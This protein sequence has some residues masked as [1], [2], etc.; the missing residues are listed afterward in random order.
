MRLKTILNACCDFKGFVVGESN[1]S[2]D[3]KSI[4]INIRARKGSKAICS[5]CGKPAP[6]YDKL[7]ERETEFIPFW[8]FLICFVYPMRRV[9]CPTCGIKVE[10]VPWIAGKHQISPHYA[11]YLAG[12]AK[13]MSWKSVAERFRTSWQTVWRCVEMVVSYGLSNRTIKG[14]AALGVDEVQYQKGHT[15]MTLVYQ[16]DKDCRRLL[17][18]GKKRTMKT[19][20]SFFTDMWHID[21]KFRKGIKVICSDMWKAYLRVI[22]EKTPK[23]I[24]VL[25]KFH[26]MK[27]LNN[28]INDVRKDEVKR[29]KKEGRDPILKNAK[30]CFLKRKFN[31]TRSQKGKLK[32]LVNMNLNTVKAYILK[33]QFHRL[34]EYNSPAWAG[35]FI[36]NWCELAHESGLEPMK[37]VANMLQSHRELILNYFRAKKEYN[38]GIVEGLN[39]KVNLTVR[40]SFGFKSFE[41]MKIALFHQLGRLPE[42]KF[43]H[44]FW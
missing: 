29:L 25:D 19:L 38:S 16:I 31:L 24:N 17:W 22:K 9:N 8:G 21:R 33:E 2:K 27:K 37:K 36:D 15:Y 6:G 28:A 18:V 35:K 43:T 34:W 11:K 32:E 23:A 26:I 39:R 1:F 41:I 42:P 5:C 20:R 10:K 30:W 14:V 7:S 12:W 44:E 3:R 13:E 40:K 4:E